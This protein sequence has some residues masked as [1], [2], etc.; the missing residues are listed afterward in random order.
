VTPHADST[1]SHLLQSILI[2]HNATIQNYRKNGR[3]PC[4]SS[5]RCIVC[6]LPAV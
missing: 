3:F 2:C 4:M 6:L 5:W 1:A